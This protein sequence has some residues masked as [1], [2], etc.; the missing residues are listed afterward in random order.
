MNNKYS[1]ITL[2]LNKEDIQKI[3][4]LM[5]LIETHNRSYL[6]RTL[7]DYFI[8]NKDKIQELIKK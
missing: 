1:S 2:S 5:I 7:I 3:D 8:K 6:I 4:D